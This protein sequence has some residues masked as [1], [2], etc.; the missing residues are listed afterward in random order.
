MAQS[1]SHGNQ[2]LF[3]TNNIVNKTYDVFDGDAS[4]IMKVNGNIFRECGFAA[5]GSY[6]QHHLSEFHDNIIYDANNY[7][8]NAA[9]QG[10]FGLNTD[11][12]E[13]YGKAAVVIGSQSG[14]TSY[15]RNRI[16][17]DRVLQ[18]PGNSLTELTQVAG[19]TMGAR[20]YYVCLTYSNDSGETLA[21]TEKS[22][23][24]SANNLLNVVPPE[25]AGLG[26]TFTTMSG[27]RKVNIYVS[28]SA[29]AETLQATIDWPIYF[30]T[31]G[32]SW[33]EPTTGLVS[34]AA[35]PVANTTHALTKYGF[36]SFN[37]GYSE[38][39][40]HSF[41]DNEVFGIATPFGYAKS[42]AEETGPFRGNLLNNKI[43]LNV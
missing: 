13:E 26:T 4:Y 5:Y 7:V 1:G 2:E 22:L 11:N 40:P 15:K 28:T 10:I 9:V 19:G 41:E 33:T 35:L 6:S 36:Y 32:R 14:G 30:N 31:G 3:F 21:S 24:V 18:N 12:L 34:G 38:G 29:G 39:Q 43:L 20:T 37:T 8:Q 17:D 16:M 25:P 23:A 27:I 42:N